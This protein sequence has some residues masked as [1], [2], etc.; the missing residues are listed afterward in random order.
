MD[1]AKTKRLA[2]EVAALNRG[3]IPHFKVVGFLPLV[4]GLVGW[5]PAYSLFRIA[6]RK[7]A[8]TA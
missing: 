7:R 8:S 2:W 3:L 6:T 5:C 4:T 1:E